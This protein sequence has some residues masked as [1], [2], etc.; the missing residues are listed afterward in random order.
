MAV[1][2]SNVTQPTQIVGTAP[3]V[4]NAIRNASPILTASTPVPMAGDDKSLA[5]FMAPIMQQVSLK[6]EFFNQLFN[7]IGLTNLMYRTYQNDLRELKQGIIDYGA[8]VQEV[9]G[10]FVHAE[11]YDIEG[12]VTKVFNLYPP[13]IRATIHPINY[14]V[15]YSY[16]IP[17]MLI[18]R[19]VVSWDGM[20]DLIDFAGSCELKTLNYDE[21]QIMMYTVARR[22]LDGSIYPVEGAAISKEN[23]EDITTALRYVSNEFTFLRTQYNVDGIPQSVPR[24]EQF[25]LL[26]SKFDAYQSVSVLAAAFNMDEA[27]FLGHRILVSSFGDIDNN[28][29]SM[30]IKDYQPISESDLQ[31][32]D[33][34]PAV[35]MGRNWF[36]VYDAPYSDGNITNPMG[37]YFNHHFVSNK[38]VDSSPYENAVVITAAEPTVTSVTISPDAPTVAKGATQQFTAE[39]V[40]TNFAPKGVTWS[41]TGQAVDGTT[42][43]QTGLLTVAANETASSIT[44][45]A[46][47]VFDTTKKDTATVTVP[48]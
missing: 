10:G 41:I 30:I 47:S 44:V 25:C 31:A 28:R 19:A 45:T 21:Y 13:D 3:Q 39:V 43:D 40:T 36:Q 37:A 2:K 48:A 14:Q 32:L 12:S 22:I 8:F 18:Q 17:Q 15:V 24:D 11:P 6:N 23:A 20:A 16:T 1:Q 42:I 5:R 29:L 35:V 27:M 38:I 34:I 26:S 9:S 4:V 33:A 46:T 7:R